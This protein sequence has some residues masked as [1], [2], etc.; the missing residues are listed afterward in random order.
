M[1]VCSLVVVHEE[2][3]NI[4]AVKRYKEE[5]LA[6]ALGKEEQRRPEHQI[7]HAPIDHQVAGLAKAGMRSIDWGLKIKDKAKRRK[8]EGDL[9]SAP[10]L[11]SE[12][13]T[14]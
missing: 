14:P 13:N 2:E 8:T 7:K 1:S 11:V 6:S 3:E 4:Q 12:P 9:Q 5:L 10:Q